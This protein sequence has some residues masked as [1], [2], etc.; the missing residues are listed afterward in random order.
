MSG[1][2][3]DTIIKFQDIVRYGNVEEL[4]CNN[5]LSKTVS[6]LMY[7][8]IYQ[9]KKRFDDLTNQL[10]HEINNIETLGNLNT[11]MTNM[12]MKFDEV[13][14]KYRDVCLTEYGRKCQ[15][16]P[17]LKRMDY[18]CEESKTNLCRLLHMVRKEY[19]DNLKFQIK[20][21]LTEIKLSESMKRFQEMV[22]GNVDKYLE[23]TV[24]QQSLAFEEIWLKCFGQ[25]DEEDKVNERDE[26][27]CDLYSRF[28]I[29]SMELE[30]QPAIYELFRSHNFN[31]E[32]VFQSIRLYITARFQLK[33]SKSKTT[34]EFIYP[35]NINHISIRDMKPYPGKESYEY[36]D[37]NQLFSLY[38]K[39]GKD[40]IKFT[41]WVPTKC[42]PL[43]QLCSGH[44]NDPDIICKDKLKQICLLSSS[45]KNPKI[46]NKNTWGI[47]V[48]KIFSNTLFIIQKDPIVSSTTVRE[49]IDNVSRTLKIVNHEISYIQAKLSIT[50]ERTISTFVF[51]VAFRSLWNIKKN[52]P[53][54]HQIKKR[55]K[56][57]NYR[58][59]FLKKIENRKMVRGGWNRERMKDSDHQI[60]KKFAKDFICGVE[61]GILNNFKLTIENLFK[62]R[63]ESLSHESIFFLANSI[64]SKELNRSEE[65]I[66]HTDNF[67]VQFICNRNE[68]MKGLFDQEWSRANEEVYYTIAQQMKTEFSKQITNVIQVLKAL[69]TDLTESSMKSGH[70]V[71]KAS[72]SD[73]NFE[74][75]SMIERKSSENQK[76]S[77]K[78]GPFKA[79]MM[80]LKMYLDPNVSPHHFQNFFANI[81]KI[82]GKQIQKSDTYI[83]CHKPSK[84][85]LDE[86]IFKKLDNTKMFNNENIYSIY[87][88]TTAFLQV[89]GSYR[90]TVSLEEF[91]NMVQSIE[92]DY[93]KEVLGCPSRCPSCGKL[94]EKKIHPRNEQCHIKTG[95]QICSMGGKVWN[96]D[97]K[98]TAVL[99]MCDDYKDHTKVTL[100][101]RTTTWGQFKEGLSACWEWELLKEEKYRTLQAHNQDKMVRIWNK[102]G[103]AILSYYA[104]EKEGTEIAYVPYISFDEVHKNLSLRYNICFVIDGTGSMHREIQKVRISVKQFISKYQEQGKESQFNVVIYRDIVTKD[105]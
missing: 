22:I 63:K 89:L 60:A 8:H 83:L 85:H 24:D 36:F 97:L 77:E 7:T 9:K 80:Y 55:E 41:D 53:L 81:F 27:F 6:N 37:G 15:T 61:R 72:D 17:L 87:E 39:H 5:L 42:L 43:V 13:F 68:A 20:S 65:E 32:A 34:E 2:I 79:M 1:T 11:I 96:N 64:I 59:Y 45:L 51:A 98:R 78:E 23:L 28:K 50:A 26:N 58:H 94:C 16:E 71:D 33:P 73:S 46:T 47:L 102:F 49:I 48:E 76:L 101:G 75:V 38:K 84:P 29:E 12:M 56:K 69:L 86:D 104:D 105:H 67:V 82:E 35:T 93:K 91:D 62:E 92:D 14:D 100:Q 95:H 40:H 99:F 54:E 10:T 57:S 31:M 74:I 21:V 18:I 70:P 4:Q 52:K 103:R 90:Y 66:L 88:Y 25:E 19:E 3:W 44:F 30:S